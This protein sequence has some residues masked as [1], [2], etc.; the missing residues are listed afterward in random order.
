[1][2]CTI[3]QSSRLAYVFK[4][5]DCASG[6]RKMAR[7]TDRNAQA[8]LLKTNK[9]SE[10]CAIGT[11]IR[12]DPEHVYPGGPDMANKTT[13]TSKARISGRLRRALSARSNGLGCPDGPIV[14][15]AI[16]KPDLGGGFRST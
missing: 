1:M 15:P 4:D 9:K 13:L 14:L 12:E 2:T 8:K 11:R 16:G 5:L 7:Y 3:A 10:L 6:S